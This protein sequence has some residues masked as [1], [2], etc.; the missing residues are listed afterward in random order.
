MLGCGYLGLSEALQSY[1]ENAGASLKHYARI[2]IR[3]RMVDA[4]R[5][6]AV[7]VAA[8]SMPLE[9]DRIT[10]S[11]PD[12]A[13]EH[14]RLDRIL[15]KITDMPDRN[16][17]IIMRSIVGESF[18]AIANDFA[19]SPRQVNRILHDFRKSLHDA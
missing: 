1:R 7:E 9:D 5:S 4:M 18:A 12:T 2:R 11:V 16:S 3:G 15:K 19:I 8:H 13:M 6:K 17:E 10:S 14:V